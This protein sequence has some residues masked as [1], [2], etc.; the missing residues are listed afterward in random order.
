MKVIRKRFLS[1]ALALMMLLSCTMVASATDISSTSVASS[2]TILTD[3]IIVTPQNGSSV[4][5]QFTLSSRAYITLMLYEN[6]P[7]CTI[8]IWG[9][10]GTAGRTISS[11]ET[12]KKFYTI[13]GSNGSTMMNPGTYQYSITFHGSA[14]SGTVIGYQFLATDNIYNRPIK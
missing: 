6:S 13:I 12:G 9:N 4:S 14:T 11:N 8:M 5:G 1:L 3:A 10:N 2:A 7:S